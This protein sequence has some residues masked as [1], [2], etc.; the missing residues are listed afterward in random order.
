MVTVWERLSFV[1][2][3]S[4]PKNPMADEDDSEV[5]P[6]LCTILSS[7]VGPL[8][9]ACVDGLEDLA[10]IA[11]LC[12]SGPH[13]ASTR[14]AILQRAGTIV[15]EAPLWSAVSNFVQDFCW[16]T[17][18][19]AAA[20][21][22]HPFFAKL[23]AP[24]ICRV[25]GS[26]RCSHGLCQKQETPKEGV[27]ELLD[28]LSRTPSNS[29]GAVAVAALECSARLLGAIGRNEKALRLW[30]QAADAGSARAQLDL[31]VRQY[32]TGTASTV[33]YQAGAHPP[34]PTAQSA[35]GAEALLWAASS[36]PTLPSLGLEGRVIRARAYMILGMMALDGDGS[37][38]D[39]RAAFDWFERAHR[40]ARERNQ[41]PIDAS[42]EASNGPGD[43]DASAPTI[44]GKYW[45]RSQTLGK[46]EYERRMLQALRDVEADAE[47][48]LQTFTQSMLFRNSR[49]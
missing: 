48:T 38:Q 21:H 2:V 29:D 8:V 33:Y 35:A 32:N 44:S 47:E 36:N 27:L 24:P 7:D 43:E 41:A 42:D 15:L 9:I 23:R 30:T 19:A 1:G 26:G 3:K 11:C 14:G 18:V 10:S 13:F 46:V 12:P 34:S 45:D 40:I 37:T 25:T 16:P 31:G 49:P 28:E 4:S 6:T 20:W 5:P 39:D 22:V 17:S